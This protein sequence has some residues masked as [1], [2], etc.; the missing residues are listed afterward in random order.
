MSADK[1]HLTAPL[2]KDDAMRK[3]ERLK[4]DAR[5]AAVL[6][7]HRLG[8][9]FHYTPE[10]AVTSCITCSAQIQVL[11]SPAPNQI[12]IGGPALALNCPVS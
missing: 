5:E 2:H 11:S 7:R 6:R 8:R 9:F 1:P 3:I 12:D 10:N 4:R